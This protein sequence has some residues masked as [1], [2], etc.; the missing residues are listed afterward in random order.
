MQREPGGSVILRGGVIVDGTGAPRFQG[1]VGISDDLGIGGGR[2]IPAS[3]ASGPVIDVSGLV[4]A[5][6]FVDMHSHS[7]L[8]VLADPAHEAKVR[9]GVTLEVLGQDGLS[10]APVTDA[11]LDP[12]RAQLAGWNG[13]PP[14][15]D[16]SWRSVGEYLDRIDAGAPVNAAYLIPHGTVRLAVLGA[17]NRAPNG[18]ELMAMQELVAQGMRDGSVGMS[19][20]LTYTPGMY[21]DDAE[22][23]A[24]NRVVA[25][26]GGYYSP[27]HR[28][29]GARVVEAYADCVT[30]AEEA[31]VPLHLAH[32][33]VNFPQNRGR[34]GE[35]LALL[36]KAQ[37]RGV[38]V[39]LDSYP[40]LASATYLHAPLPSWAHEGGP[41]ATLE[42]LR[43]PA[44]RARILHEIEVTGSD[45]HHGVPIDWAT[46]VVT[47]VQDPA[48]EPHVGQSIAALGGGERYLDLLVADRLG[49]SCRIE[50]GN[51]ENV[52]TVMTSPCHTVGSDG[53]LA[54]SRPHPR[55]WGTFPRY[56]GHYTRE[57][58]VLT[59]EEC[60]E[61]M[62]S[63]PAR[64]L[65]VP[66]RGVV[67][68]GY[69]ADLVCF[70]PDTVRAN[71]TFDEPRQ[72]P[73]GI[74]HVLIAGEFTVRDGARTDRLPGRTVRGRSWTP[75]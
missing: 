1:D 6:G 38:D 37:A 19:A 27:H 61:R 22:L 8:A 71:A 66:D 59:L 63:R 44:Q 39:S 33:H 57:L 50:V 12:L 4:V 67:A 35:V 56:L 20:G 31:G 74:P 16:W 11:T 36:E 51:E 65:G 34:A 48:L 14:G 21:A 30:I 58:G 70:D 68:P 62:T 75:T 55:A 3:D 2:I 60:V 29:Y 28:N 45:G 7:D 42:R 9:Q 25:A 13:D 64:R 10:Y 43:D 69:R 72:P 32:C 47:G 17:E 26:A 49:S 54:G 73:D 24:L 18:A 46:I 40:Y 23:V 15:L 52:R 5:P 53:I 41:D